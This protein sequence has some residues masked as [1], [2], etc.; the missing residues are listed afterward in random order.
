MYEI[1]MTK[2]IVKR[3]VKWNCILKRLPYCTSRF[4][5]FIIIIMMI[6]LS[7]YMHDNT[8]Y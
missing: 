7:F 6:V 8:D 3:A 4:N 2:S 5:F 1:N